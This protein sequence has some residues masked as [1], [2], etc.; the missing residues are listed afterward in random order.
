MERSICLEYTEW[1]GP[2]QVA[3]PGKYDRG[4]KLL[5]ILHER[6]SLDMDRSTQYTFLQWFVCL[7]KP[8]SQTVCLAPGKD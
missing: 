5:S 7:C 8:R 6:S 3:R 1:T 2:C 4:G